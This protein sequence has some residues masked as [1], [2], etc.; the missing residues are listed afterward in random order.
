MQALLSADETDAQQSWPAELLELRDKFT[1]GSK[2]EIRELTEQHSIELARL[3]DEHS[4]ILSRNIERHSEEVNRIKAELQKNRSGDDNSD[5]ENLLV[6][7]RY[8]N[9]SSKNS[10]T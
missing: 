6:R 9:R 8:E 1:D 2:R 5:Q 10:D 4:R 3:R 7:E